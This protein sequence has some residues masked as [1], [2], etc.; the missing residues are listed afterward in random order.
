[1]VLLQSDVALARAAE[2]ALVQGIVG[3]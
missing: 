1:L 3:P 2:G